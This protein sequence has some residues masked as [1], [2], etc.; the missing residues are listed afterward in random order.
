MVATV[1]E[2]GKLHMPPSS[3]SIQSQTVCSSTS[4]PHLLLLMV[5]AAVVVAEDADAAGRTALRRKRVLVLALEDCACKLVLQHSSTQRKS[6]RVP[7]WGRMARQKKT[8]Y[9]RPDDCPVSV[10]FSLWSGVNADG[11]Y[12]GLL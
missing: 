5:V 1:P 6:I 12:L 10:S 11:K 3:I 2:G 4:K 9:L 8:V 7:S